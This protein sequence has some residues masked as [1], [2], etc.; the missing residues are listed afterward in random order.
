MRILYRAVLLLVAIFV[1]LFAASNRQT[2]AIGLWPLPFLADVPLYLPCFLGLLIGA[3]I[4]S[5]VSW[6]ARRPARRELRDCRRRIHALERE[7]AATH[8]QLENE[9]G[10]AFSADRLPG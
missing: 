2:V 10:A 4:G 8:S 7:L 9:A 1:I 6:M 3:L 5:S